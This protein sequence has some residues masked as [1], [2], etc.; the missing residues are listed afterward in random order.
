MAH[1]HI[2]QSDTPV[3]PTTT[4]DRRRARTL[5]VTPGVHLWL[6]GTPLGLLDFGFRP[7]VE[8]RQIEGAGHLCVRWQAGVEFPDTFKKMVNFADYLESVN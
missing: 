7:T 6:P 3:G 8:R 5:A 4:R 2:H 1:Q